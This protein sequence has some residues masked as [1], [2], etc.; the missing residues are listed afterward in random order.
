MAKRT[1]AYYKELAA[2]AN[3]V[4][5]LQTISYNAL[6]DDPECTA[7]SGKYDKI[8]AMCVKREMELRGDDK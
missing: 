7:F 8:V 5:E 3:T 6:R 2:Q 4:E 1:F